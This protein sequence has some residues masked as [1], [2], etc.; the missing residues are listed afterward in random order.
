MVTRTGRPDKLAVGKIVD[1]ENPEQLANAILDILSF[2]SK[3]QNALSKRA[4]G[5]VHKLIR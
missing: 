1:K 2:A 4:Y 5:E 3:D